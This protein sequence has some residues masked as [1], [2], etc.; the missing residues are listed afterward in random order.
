MGWNH[1]LEIFCLTH[2]TEIYIKPFCSQELSIE[3]LDRAVVQPGQLLSGAEFSSKSW[4]IDD[5]GTMEKNKS[6]TTWDT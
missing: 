3:G 1:Q 5:T 2:G 6:C 4:L